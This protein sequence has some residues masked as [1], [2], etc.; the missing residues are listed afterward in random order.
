MVSVIIPSYNSEETIV[1][2]LDALQNQSYDKPYEIILV[3]SS[4]DRTP[5]IV[6]QSYPEIKF[7]HLKE[8]TDP[9]SAR[10]LGVKESRGDIILFIDSDCRAERD[11]IEKMVVRH[12][13]SDYGAVGGAVLNGND[14]RSAVAWAGYLAE[15][16]EFI[17]EHP[18]REVR[19]IP[20]CNISYKRNVL[21]EYLPFNREYYPQEDLEL[22]YRL[23]K[24]GYKIFF[25]PA[26]RIYHHHRTRFGSFLAHQ[27]TVGRIT[28]RMIGLL[29]LEGAGFVHN[30]IL[31]VFAIP[32]LPFVKWLRT[33]A[34]FIRLQP[35]ILLRHP[36]AAGLLG[37]GLISWAIGFWQGV[38]R[39]TEGN[40]R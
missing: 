14:P 33:M 32:F 16:R 31:A 36:A 1:F 28:A 34:L 2:C 27:K 40:D 9:G 8:K 38:F 30:K 13:Q 22:N 12:R 29:N 25:D 15:F 26:I 24:A 35:G 17:P 5:D 37:I 11:W 3:D 7:I 23:T 10:S 18:A 21:L 6:R 4:V 39:S 19:H 20:T